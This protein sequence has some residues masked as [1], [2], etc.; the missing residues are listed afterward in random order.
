MPNQ[1]ILS[2][3]IDGRHCGPAED[4]YTDVTDPSTGEVYAAAPLSGE[5]DVD[6]AYAAAGRAFESWRHSTPSERQQAL[7]KIADGVEA[8]ADELVEA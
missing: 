1:L 4:R 8:R 5:A 6:R 7:L 2:N 3:F